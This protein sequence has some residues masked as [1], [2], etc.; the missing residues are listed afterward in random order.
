MPP[1]NWMTAAP[2][3]V[4]GEGQQQTES[5]SGVRLEQEQD[6]FALLGCLIDT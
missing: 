4:D 6:R 5:R 2:G 3:A 1:K